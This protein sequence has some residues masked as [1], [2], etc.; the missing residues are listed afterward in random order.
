LQRE[1][2][3]PRLLGEEAVTQTPR[4]LLMS[5][6]HHP[7]AQALA[8]V[9]IGDCSPG[10]ALLVARHTEVCAEC[11]GRVRQM[12][13]RGKVGCADPVRGAWRQLAAGVEVAP[14]GG[15]AGLGEAVYDIRAQAAAD[16]QVEAPF[17]FL[18]L[19]VL[20]GSFERDGKLYA[21]GDFLC[22]A[23]RS[24]DAA[25]TADPVIGFSGLLIVHA[26][27]GLDLEA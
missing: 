7:G 26:E 5:P 23:G 17:E 14:L 24:A 2:V 4:P 15:V 21:A 18:E 13:P 12:D 20:E 9:L 1:I 11:R 6:K 16:V 8:D 3:V 27:D 22:F 10:T 25:L 19:L